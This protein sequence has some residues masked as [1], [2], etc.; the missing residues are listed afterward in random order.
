MQLFIDNPLNAQAP[1]AGN[2]APNP[3]N[4]PAPDPANGSATG[5]PQANIVIVDPPEITLPV[6]VAA[7][8]KINAEPDYCTR[9]KKLHDWKEDFGD[10][11]TNIAKTQVACP[12]T[13][14]G[15][16]TNHAIE[17]YLNFTLNG[18]CYTT[19]NVSD[20]PNNTTAAGTYFLSFCTDALT[21]ARESRE[22]VM[23]QTY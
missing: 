10:N 20:P 18:T 6:I 11:C 8:D 22:L 19:Q 21:M 4:G 1:D 23:L 2:P 17:K 15:N 12:E 7:L 9:M 13:P 16:V 14:V 5:G 3:A